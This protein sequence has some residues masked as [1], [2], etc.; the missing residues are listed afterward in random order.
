MAT[1]GGDI[2]GI[3]GRKAVLNR[4]LDGPANELRL[5]SNQLTCAASGNQATQVDGLVVSALSSAN[6]VGHLVQSQIQRGDRLIGIDGEE[7]RCLEVTIPT[8][9][10][11]NP[12]ASVKK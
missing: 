6:D 12:N 7:A 8:V 5:D 10:R 11:G 2:G 3:V 1:C 9:L 4:D